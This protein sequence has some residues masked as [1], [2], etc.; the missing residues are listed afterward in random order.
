MLEKLKKL[1]RKS[2]IQKILNVLITLT[3]VLL[4]NVFAVYYA[5]K[6]NLA[7]PV[8]PK[9]FAFEIFAPNT[10]KGF[11]LTVGLLIA[12]ILKFFKQNLIAI[13]ICLIVITTYYFTNFDPNLTE[14][15][16]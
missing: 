10:A 6:M 14:N 1:N 8:I 16:K 13:V 2:N 3:L 5:T 12:T 15:Q 11:I 7:N 9:Y 4:L